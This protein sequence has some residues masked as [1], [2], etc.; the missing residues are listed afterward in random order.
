MYGKKNL[1]KIDDRTEIFMEKYKPKTDGETFLL[2]KKT[3]C[4]YDAT[5]W[6]SF[7]KQNKTNRVCW[8]NLD[9]IDWSFAS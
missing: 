1:K 8:K 3:W 4:Q 5:M 9:V 7:A 2:T 6:T